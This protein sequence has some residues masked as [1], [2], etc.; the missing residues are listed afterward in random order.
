RD[1]RSVPVV[2][3]GSSLTGVDGA[4]LPVLV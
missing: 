1:A 2:D 4:E 3:T